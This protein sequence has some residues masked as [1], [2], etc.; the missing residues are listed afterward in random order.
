[1]FC[2]FTLEL[3]EV[4]VQCPIWIF[5]CS[6]LISYFPSMLLRCCVNDFELVLVALVITGITFAFIFHM[7]YIS[8]VRSLYFKIFSASFGL[9]NCNI[10]YCTCSFFIVTNYD[11]WFIV[12]NVFTCWFH[13]M[14]TLPS[15]LVSSYFGCCYH[16]HHRH[17]YYYYYYSCT[18][19]LKTKWLRP[20]C[21]IYMSLFH[22][23]LINRMPYVHYGGALF[24]PYEVLSGVLKQSFLGPLL[25][26]IFVNDLYGQVF[27]SAFSLLIT[28]K[29]F[30]ALITFLTVYYFILI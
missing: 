20:I 9:W 27:K 23:Y 24:A 25:F 6:S 26:N 5:F 4:C 28:Q 21:C 18:A 29:F 12:W 3:S 15:Q 11:V 22:S 7:C 10:Y 1:M 2:A 13:N 16:H 19:P 14:V 8:V 30:L 17:Y